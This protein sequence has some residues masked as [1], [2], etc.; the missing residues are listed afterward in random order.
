[1]EKNTPK[2]YCGVSTRDLIDYFRVFHLFYWKWYFG[3][4]FIN[5]SVN[6]NLIICGS[7]I[8]WRSLLQLIE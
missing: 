3:K 5:V 8:L 4:T 7:I 1:M 2:K 6:S